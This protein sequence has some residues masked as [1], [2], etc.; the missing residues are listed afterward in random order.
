MRK[1]I[2][3]TICLAGTIAFAQDKKAANLLNV[4]S[5]KTQSFE[6]TK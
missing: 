5:E 6:Y 4:V 2:L 3:L 1:I